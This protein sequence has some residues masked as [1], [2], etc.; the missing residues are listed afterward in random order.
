MPNTVGGISVAS[1]LL[2]N[3]ALLNLNRTQASLST[4]VTQLS[5]GLRVNFA[6]A[7]AGT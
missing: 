7:S 4:L 1:N 3:T 2:A 5:S 6:A